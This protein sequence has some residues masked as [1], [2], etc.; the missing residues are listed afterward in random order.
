M[1]GVQARGRSARRTEVKRMPAAG[2]RHGARLLVREAGPPSIPATGRRGRRGRGS[3]RRSRPPRRGR[4][5]RSRGRRGR[6]RAGPAK[7]SSASL[8][9]CRQTTSGC[10]SSS[11][12]SS[13]GTRC[14]TEFTF[15]VAIRTAVHSNV[16]GRARRA[17]PSRAMWWCPRERYRGPRTTSRWEPP[18]RRPKRR[19]G[20][21]TDHRRVARPRQALAR[22]PRRSWRLV[23]DAA[24]PP[25]WRRRARAG[26]D[27]GGR[28]AARRRR[29]PRARA[30][31]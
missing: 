27:D 30:R 10:R 19:H 13:R 28:R 9:S 16:Q 12:G 17:T 8:V 24:G 31:W 7:A 11:H 5:P 25:R 20:H 1:L 15:Q 3:P 14:L 29:R 23:I 6:R 18:R 26:G 22:E 21:G 4:R 2:G